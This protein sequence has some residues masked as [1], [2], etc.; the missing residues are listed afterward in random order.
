MGYHRLEI[1]KHSVESP[2]KILEEFTEYIDSISSGNKIMAIQELSDLY[3]CLENEISKYNMNMKD[4]K[5]MS[6][7]TKKVFSEGSRTSQTLLDYLKDNFDSINSFGLGFIQVKC[8]NINYNFY[9]KDIEMFESS[10]SPHSH[11]QDFVSE[12]IKGFLTEKLYDVTPGINKAFCGCGDPLSSPLYLNYT[13]NSIKVYSEGDLYL[14]LSGEYHSVS[15]IHGTITKV[16][17][18]GSK[19]DAYV[20][21]DGIKE[22][23]STLKEED[24]WRMVDEIYNF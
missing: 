14:R 10:K 18:Y 2:F 7:T 9:H 3:G 24:L 15:A 22:T 12:I 17:K 4:L 13:F 23:S 20:I 6:D 8:Q 19:S 5:T 1:P 11:Q 16:V 21:Y